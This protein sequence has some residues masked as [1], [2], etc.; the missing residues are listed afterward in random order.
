MIKCD[1]GVEQGRGW[2]RIERLP[3]WLAIRLAG[4]ASP[5]GIGERVL[6][7]GSGLG[8]A[9]KAAKYRGGTRLV[10]S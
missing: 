5:V 1:D 10:C 9:G 3:V 4:G 2:E 8:V 6:G 7:L